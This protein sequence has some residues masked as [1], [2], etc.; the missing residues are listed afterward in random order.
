MVEMNYILI[1]D[2]FG[3]SDTWYGGFHGALDNLL[4]VKAGPGPA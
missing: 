4:A 2:R 3:H 1:R